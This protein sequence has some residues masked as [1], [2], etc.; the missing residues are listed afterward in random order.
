VSRATGVD[1]PKALHASH[2]QN[3]KRERE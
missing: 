3:K 1:Q 2:L